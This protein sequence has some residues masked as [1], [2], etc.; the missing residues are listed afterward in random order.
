MIDHGFKVELGPLDSSD[1]DKIRSWR[2]D[3]RIW[4]WCRQNDLIS[5]RDQRKWFESQ[6]DDR[7]IKMYTIKPKG[8]DFMVG[9]CGLTSIDHVNRRAEFS[10]YI[11]PTYQGCG[12]ATEALKTLCAH[13]FKSLNLNS[14]WGESFDG[15][16]ATAMFE[17]I[18]FKKE[19]TRREFYFKDGRYVDAHLYSLLSR[20]FL[21]WLSDKSEAKAANKHAEPVTTGTKVK[22]VHPTAS[23][24]P[25]Q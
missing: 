17:K 18:G 8:S 3:Q 16:K 25:V 24:I 4:A 22:R 2:N 23:K 15:N 11:A 1:L 19:G 9:V 7:C 10:L 21:A 13:G 12:Y 14:I 5:D 6:S 20:E